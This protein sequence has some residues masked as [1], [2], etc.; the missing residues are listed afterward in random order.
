MKKLI[1][2]IFVIILSTFAQAPKELSVIFEVAG[3]DSGALLGDYVKGVGDL[4]KDGYDDVAVSASGQLLTYIYYGDKTM[5]QQPS[6]T[7]EGGGTITFGDFN[8]DSWI[9]LVIEKKYKDTVNVFWGSLYMDTIPDVTLRAENRYD[10]FGRNSLGSGDING[11]GI[12]DLIIGAAAYPY[13]DT[14]NNNYWRGKIYVYAGKSQFDTIPKITLEGDTTRNL[15]GINISSGDINK[16]GNY[17]ILALGFNELSSSGDEQF[18]YF[19]VYLG[20]SNFNLRRNYYIDSRKFSG[21]FRDHITCFDSDGDGIDNILV[22]KVYIF[23]GGTQLDTVPTYYIPPPNNDTTNFG[24]YPWVRGGGDFNGDGFKDMLI[25]RTEG[26]P[27]G[28]PGFYLYLNRLN[29]PSQYVA[30][31][32]FSENP[33][34]YPLYGRPENAGDVNGDG[35]DDIITS[36]PMEPLF[37]NNGLF[38]IYS[39]DTTLVTDIKEKEEL[40]P[41]GFNLKQNYPNPFNPSTTIEYTLPKE[42]KVT[43]K[44]FDTI[45]KEI[46][47]L[48]NKN[49]QRGDYKVVWDGTDNKG[50]K[51]SS[52]IY[53]YWLQIDK[54]VITK[55]AI[56]LK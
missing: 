46:K 53:F 56:F 31:R 36:S 21:G 27:F 6:L 51:V 7:L 33:F 25:S 19:S 24:L 20:N 43:L 2:L 55:K 5:N 13:T 52:G 32:V 42:G 49:Q 1:I 14:V 47:T 17:D 9:D 44:I 50:E 30:Y 35:V 34:K 48:V 10:G 40:N 41:E 11:D 39:G 29:Y 28:V 26:Y 4:N 38:G 8:G 3:K 22:N 23:K 12:V 16:D 37:K 18:F 54:T 15:L 45:G